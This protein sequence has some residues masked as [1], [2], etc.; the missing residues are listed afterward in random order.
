[1]PCVHDVEEWIHEKADKAISVP[2]SPSDSVLRN[3]C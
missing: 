3:N 1:M 2:F